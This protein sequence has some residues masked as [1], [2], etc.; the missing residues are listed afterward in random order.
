V[1]IETCS[2]DH[3]VLRLNGAIRTVGQQACTNV[4]VQAGGDDAVFVV[5]LISFD[6]EVFTGQDLRGFAIGV[7]G[8]FGS[9]GDERGGN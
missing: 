5:E 8:V 4:G 1:A 9:C 7:E 6:I 3:I 2:F